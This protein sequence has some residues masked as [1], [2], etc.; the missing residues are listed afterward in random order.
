[1]CFPLDLSKYYNHIIYK[2]DSIEDNP[3]LNK[4]SIYG[5]PH[6]KNIHIIDKKFS[7]ENSIFDNLM[8]DGQN[9]YINK[10]NINNIAFLG[11]SE[12]GTVCDEV[13]INTIDKS[14][15]SVPLVLK[16]FHSDNF[17]GIDDGEKN[18]ECKLAFY[19][20]GDDE[21]KHGVFFWKVNLNKN[22]DINYLELPVNCSMHLFAITL[23]LVNHLYSVL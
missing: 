2:N 14:V 7:S 23:T 21:Q 20:N 1:M 8:C 15:L 6:F 16:T 5:L 10:N 11:F 3:D 17:K 12:M 18:S 19:M 9:I 22:Y 4:K 13:M